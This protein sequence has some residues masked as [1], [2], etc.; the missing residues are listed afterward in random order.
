MKQETGTTPKFKVKATV[1][2]D[3]ALQELFLDEIMDLYWA[4]N[5]LVKS[6]PKMIKAASSPALAAAIENHLK[7]TEEHVSRLEQIFKLLGK[8]ALAK[9]CDAMEGLTKE[10]EGVIESTPVG[11]ATRDVGIILASQKVEHYE[12]ASYGGLLQL[13]A[14]LGLQEV[15]ELLELTLGEEQT[16]DAMLTE[17]AE[18]KINYTAAQEL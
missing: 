12:I 10:A 2:A 4:E 5:H 15:A 13:A 11:T 6:L 18:N 1:K 3:P 14:T 9:K 7:E 17:V 8:E 16:A